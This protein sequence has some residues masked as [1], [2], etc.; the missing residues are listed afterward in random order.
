MLTVFRSLKTSPK[1][2]SRPLLMSG[3]C[4]QLLLQ[5]TALSCSRVSSTTAPPENFLGM[6]CV[7]QVSSHNAASHNCRIYLPMSEISSA[8]ISSPACHPKYLIKSSAFW[9]RHPCA[10][11]PKSASD[12]GCS[13]MTTWYGIGCVSNI[14]IGSVPSAAGVYRC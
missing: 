14:S 9:T 3:R 1:A 4:S 5:S 10:K 11:Q 2:I 13:Q 7:T 8:S 6:T 12:G